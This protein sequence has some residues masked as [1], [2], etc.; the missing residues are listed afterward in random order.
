[1][2]PPPT[3]PDPPKLSQA[4]KQIEKELD[5]LLIQIE[6][7]EPGTIEESALPAS[8]VAAQAASDDS[9]SASAAAAP[10]A[11]SEIEALLNE[12]PSAPAE[13]N[14]APVEETPSPLAME[15][16]SDSS[17]TAPVDAEQA[18]MLAKLNSALQDLAVGDTDDTADDEAAQPEPTIANEVEEQSTEPAEA[19]SMEDKLQ[20]EIAALMN[21][22]P[23]ETPVAETDTASAVASAGGTAVADAPTTEDQIAME[24]EGLLDAGPSEAAAEPQPA[25]ADPIDELDKMLA[26]E[27]DEDDEL[28]GDF[29]TVEDITA[30][31][32]ISDEPLESDDAHAASARDVA[33]E[34]D[35]QPEDLPAGSFSQPDTLQDTAAADEPA[36]DPFAVISQLAETAEH[37]EAEHERQTASQ[38]RDVRHWFDLAKEKLY[39]ACYALNWP[40]RRFL[41]AEWRANL[42]YIA[43]L[44]LFFGL[45]LW[46]VLIVF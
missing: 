33:A 6:S 13:E 29:Q 27:I 9:E 17:E 18:D 28:A 5:E 41:T 22:E 44:N 1:M 11:E 16:A 19:L 24:I 43:I 4:E 36:E 45:G 32:Q 20:Q 25:S 39:A 21:S 15:N 30:G 12:P 40:A 26:Q 46:I 35:S 14:E 7:V 31:I 10:S 42:G 2:T 34:L 37:N 8:Y 3:Q 23:D 38:S